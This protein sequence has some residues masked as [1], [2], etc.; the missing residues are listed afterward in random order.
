M[1]HR[2]S[3]KV[4]VHRYRS[5][6][7]YITNSDFLNPSDLTSPAFEVEYEY[8]AFPP[9]SVGFSIGHYDGSA[10]FNTICCSKIALKTTYAR[11]TL[12]FNFQPV[13]LRPLELYAGPGFGYDRIH[14]KTTI[15]GVSEQVSNRTFD[16]H[17][18]AG[19]RFPL[20]PRLSALMEAQ[21]ASVQVQEVNDLGDDI[22]FGG[23][24]TFVG[25]TWHFPDFHHILPTIS[26]PASPGVA[27]ADAV[28]P[29]DKSQ[30]GEKPPEQT[31]PSQTPPAQTPPG[32]TVPSEN[33]Q[34]KNPSAAQPEDQ[35]S[36][37]SPLPPGNSSSEPPSAQ[38]PPE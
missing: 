28:K 8:L 36:P 31:P 5:S 32:G 18:V 6:Q 13:V 9:A 23:L 29:E 15:L 16:L 27:P 25:L 3:V 19:A 30:T 14:S 33:Q 20:G 21:Y 11:M 12:K 2:L 37:T 35:G 34:Q 10:N 1:W 24:T 17:L 7:F 4:G 22:N 38:E 26:T